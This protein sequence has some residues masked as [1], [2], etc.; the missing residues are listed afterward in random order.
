MTEAIEPDATGI[1]PPLGEGT[2][3]DAAVS[4]PAIGTVTVIVPAYNEKGIAGQVLDDLVRIMDGSGYNYEIIFVDDGSEDETWREAQQRGVKLI[5]H[6]TNRGYGASLKT[7]IRAAEG[8]VIVITDADATYPN[9]RIPE[10][11]SYMD[12]CQMVVGAR[13]GQHVEIPLLRRPAK[14]LLTRLANYLAETE[15][16]DLNSGLRAFRKDVARRFLPILPSRF[17]FTTTITLAFLTNDYAVEYVPIDYYSRRGRSK[18][19]PIHDTLYF[20]LLILRT[21][22]S[23]NP[24]RV[25]LPLSFAMW[26]IGGI[27]AGWHLYFEGGFSDSSV[28]IL[29]GSLQVGAFGF[30]ADLVIRN[31]ALKE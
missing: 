6:R 25:F 28:L 23:F 12:R 17:S 31:R 7:G 14:W 8:D 13:T 18:I 21:V 16:P 29:T 26:L 10:L 20:L 27:D 11:L 4:R 30:L 2:R 24:L 9:D 22:T 15:I 19:R 1:A 3:R 5:R